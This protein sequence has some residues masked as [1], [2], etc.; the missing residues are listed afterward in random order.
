M[1]HKVW[2]FGIMHRR[3]V[4]QRIENRL[5]IQLAIEKIKLSE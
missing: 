4:Y 1:K 2:I 3:D 5:S